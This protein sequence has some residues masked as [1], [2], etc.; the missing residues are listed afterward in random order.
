[1]DNNL[2]IREQKIKDH[3]LVLLGD[4]GSNYSLEYNSALNILLYPI[5]LKTH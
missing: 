3:N 1:M 4:Y 2:H 5:Q